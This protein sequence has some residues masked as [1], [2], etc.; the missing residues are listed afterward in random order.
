M[1]FGI[2]NFNFSRISGKLTKIPTIQ[3]NNIIQSI[4]NEI[5]IDES[6]VINYI[7]EN[8][9]TNYI[10]ENIILI[11]PIKINIIYPSLNN[12]YEK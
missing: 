11:E 4:K 5:S 8:L 2:K 3:I 1:T 6:I 7:D 9:V 12:N 10:D